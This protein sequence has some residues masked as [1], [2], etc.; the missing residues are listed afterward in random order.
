MAPTWSLR[1][2]PP[3]NAAM[4][5]PRLMRMMSANMEPTLDC[6]EGES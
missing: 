3:L 5:A 1:I 4:S 6:T 2:V